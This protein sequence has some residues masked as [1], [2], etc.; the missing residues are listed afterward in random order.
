MSNVHIGILI[1]IA[2]AIIIGLSISSKKKDQPSTPTF[3]IPDDVLDMNKHKF[4]YLSTVPLDGFCTFK[5]EGEVTFKDWFSKPNSGHIAIITRCDAEVTSKIWGAGLAMGRI[6]DATPDGKPRAMIESWSGV[7]PNDHWIYPETS[8]FELVDNVPIKLV[9][10]TVF[11]K[12]GKRYCHY[13]ISQNGNEY[14]S[15]LILD[16]N[17]DYDPTK[18]GF[19]IAYDKCDGG[20]IEFKNMLCSRLENSTDSN[21]YAW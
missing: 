19:A 9:V 3:V 14:D 5:F 17:N 1:A 6:G 15:G 21:T 13:L 16:F 7:N 2:V 8:S 18:N 20:S 11:D 10:Y 12:S 4:V